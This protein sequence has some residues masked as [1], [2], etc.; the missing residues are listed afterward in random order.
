MSQRV[1]LAL[2]VLAAFT[3]AVADPP[4]GK[5]DKGIHPAAHERHDDRDGVALAIELVHAAITAPEARR[6]AERHGATGY[7]PLPP[8]IRKNLARGKPMPPGIAKTRAPG[9]MLGDLPRHDGYE[10]RVAGTDLL[11]VQLGTAVVAEVLLDVFD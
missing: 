3:P 5:P 1:L 8:G 2:L 9:A 4:R 7:K 11:L 10:W 6:L